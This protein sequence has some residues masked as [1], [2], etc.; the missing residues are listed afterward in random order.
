MTKKF[1]ILASIWSILSAN[2]EILNIHKKFKLSKT[3]SATIDIKEKKILV[4][5]DGNSFKLKDAPLLEEIKETVSIVGKESIIVIDD[6][7]FDGYNDIGIA[8]AVGYGGVN[9]FRN[10]Y[11]YEPKDKS[12]HNYLKD[13]GT[14][15]I[16][17][18]TLSSTVKSGP[19]YYQVQYEIIDNKP[20]KKLEKKLLFDILGISDIVQQFD[21]KGKVIKNYFDPEYLTILSEKAYFYNKPKDSEKTKVYVIKGDKVKVIDTEESY[22]WVKIEYKSKK[23]VYKKWIKV[24]AI[25]DSKDH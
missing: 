8:N 18:K 4:T 20:Y 13:V 7:N 14:L 9:I 16:E 25:Q 22:S 5:I 3:P 2:E 17:G 12:F 24:D 23:R 21:T 6:Y 10:Y 15:E 19:F 11:F 1:L